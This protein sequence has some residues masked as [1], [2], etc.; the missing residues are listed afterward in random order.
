M[1]IASRLLVARN[2]PDTA[3]LL[4]EFVWHLVPVLNP[5]GYDFTHSGRINRLWRKN[6]SG[7]AADNL[8][9][10]L[11]EQEQQGGEAGVVAPD[12]TTVM[13]SPHGAR[14]ISLADQ[15]SRQLCP[16]VDLNRFN[17][18]LSII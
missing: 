16:G 2:S 7:A 5:D 1:Y 13:Q 14:R 15:F 3:F 18:S 4:D 9:P 11:A 8:I 17:P 6:R 10:L 12:N